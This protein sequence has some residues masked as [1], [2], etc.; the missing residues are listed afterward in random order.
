MTKAIWKKFALIW[1][2]L[3]KIEIF[4]TK[5]IIEIIAF[6]MICS[7]QVSKGSQRRRWQM[8]F[9]SAVWILWKCYLTY[10]FEKP[11]RMWL[12]KAART[13]YRSMIKIQIYFDRIIYIY[14]RYQNVRHLFETFEK[15][16]NESSRKMKI[17]IFFIYLNRNKTRSQREYSHNN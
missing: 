9:Q 15:L 8:L 10:W 5:S 14:E 4:I 17:R 12:P 11:K 1:E 16:W 6:M 13:Y 7:N 2:F 3:K